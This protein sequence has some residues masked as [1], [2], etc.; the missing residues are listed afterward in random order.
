MS[1]NDHAGA[2]ADFSQ[3]WMVLFA[4]MTGGFMV[5]VDG[6]V[7]NLIL[8]T[9]VTDLHTSFTVVQWVIISYL[10][11]ITSLVMIM[12][13]LGDLRGK[14]GIYLSG[15][16]L[17]TFGSLL[18]GFAG[19]IWWLLVFRIIQ[20]IGGAM[21]LA[22]GFAIVTEAFPAAER[23]KAMGILASVVTLG[24][25]TGPVVGGILVDILSW[26]WIFF[27]NLP[28]GLCGIYMVNTYVVSAISPEQK[29]FDLA[30]AILFFLSM[31]SIV[32]GLTLGK[33]NGFISLWPIACFIGFL[34]CGQVFLFTEKRVSSPIIELG[35]FKDISL[36]A[37][38]LVMFLFYFVIGGF[39]ILAP[40][41]F[42]N[43]LG[44]TP[45]R[46]GILFGAMSMAMVFLSPFSG[47]LS[48][49]MG[50][51]TII[52]VS[53]LILLTTCVVFWR[54]LGAEPSGF[55]CFIGMVLVGTAM[56]LYMSPSHSAVMGIVP[57]KYLGIASSLLIL[58]RTLGQM[59][60]VAFWSVV[61]VLKTEL[62]STA[63]FV[64]ITEA[65]VEA[66]INGL[67]DLSIL[68]AA[69]IGAAFIVVSLATVKNK[70]N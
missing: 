36:T 69:L 67:Q 35:L 26:H 49:R 56:G 17:F 5:S 23:G 34:V 66:R 42:Q 31:L 1:K 29:G 6:S 57:Q 18:C 21:V 55:A 9:L 22:L 48:D 43:I 16:I 24:L 53:L 59:V 70:K 7:V 68:M 11:V 44:L 58:C 52:G 19:T 63:S 25:V 61:W 65:S 27:I 30:G 12:G 37:N 39:F 38:L 4:V 47:M 14:K 50:T 46:I 3:K 28:L 60:G 10:L 40:F 54:Y 13:R 45:N 64:H 2:A 15:F 33:N 20:G 62:H 51:T 32:I 8:P 41:F